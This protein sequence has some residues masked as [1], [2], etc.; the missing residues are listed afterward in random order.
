MFYHV[1]Y[2]WLINDLTAEQRTD[3]LR[4][5][6]TLPSVATIQRAHI[7]VPA[8]TDR[9]VIDSS[10]SYALICEFVDKAAQDTYLNHPIHLQFVQ[11]CAQYWTRVQVYDSEAILL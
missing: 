9:E 8:A 5:L 6:R 2:F 7:G 3:F 10:Y 4:G 1:V 11:D